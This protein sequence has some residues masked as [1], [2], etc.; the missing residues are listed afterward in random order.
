[1]PDAVMVTGIIDGEPTMHYF[2]P[3]GTHRTFAVSL[4]DESWRYWNDDPSFAQRFSGVFSSDGLEI[5]CRAERSH[6]G[7]ATWELDIAL[8][9][10][11]LDPI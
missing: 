3:R 7:G 5:S 4:S 1:M 9:Y 2:D 11:R 10:R 8:T 6:D